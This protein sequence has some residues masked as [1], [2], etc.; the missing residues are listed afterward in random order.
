MQLTERTPL[1]A[2][3]AKHPR[4]A[5]VF[6]KYRI[7]YCCGGD[8]PLGEACAAAGVTSSH[9]IDD[10]ARASSE[11]SSD[12]DWTT[13]ALAEL[14][15]HIVA[16]HHGYLRSELP[17]LEARLAK[18]ADAHRERHGEMLSALGAVFR[19]LLGELGPHLQK[20]ERALFPVIRQYE[21]AHEAGGR[22]P[23]PPFGSV[24]NPIRVME[25][26]HQSAGHALGELRRLSGDYTV[27]PDGCATFRALYEGLE[28][29]EMDLH[30]HIHLENNIL[31]PRAAGLESSFE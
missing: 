16:V 15:D 23:V 26:E 17:V 13:A 8:R 7:D 4:A 22:R 2:I 25:R 30:R 27:P 12:R 18:V 11:S 9:V 5:N 19:E 14:V 3:V 28:R 1:G 29:L 20:E 10:I 21:Q 6:E 24:R 31:F